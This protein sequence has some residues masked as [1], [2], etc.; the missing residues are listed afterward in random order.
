MRLILIAVALALI[1]APAVAQTKRNAAPAPAEERVAIPRPPLCDPLNLIPGCKQDDGSIF[2]GG[3]K[4]Q[5]P[6]AALIE[7]LTDTDDA[8]NLATSIPAVQDPVGGS[9]WKSFGGISAVSKAHPNLL[10]GKASADLEAL[11]LVHIALNQV[12]ANPNCGQMW[13][14]LS[15]AVAAL[16]PVPLPM[17]LTSICAKIPVI[18][19]NAAQSAPPV[20]T[21]APKPNP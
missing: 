2:S 11:R 19:T 4:S 3:G 10:T 7:M 6:I 18:G 5:S 20:V 17:S 13:N 14:D 16:R 9:C 1:A 12:C 15:N 8:I 21:P